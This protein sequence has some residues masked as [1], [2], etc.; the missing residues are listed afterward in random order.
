MSIK[1]TSLDSFCRG[2]SGTAP[3]PGRKEDTAMSDHFE[4]LCQWFES[5]MVPVKTSDLHL[6]MKELANSNEVYSLKHLKRKLEERYKND[7]IISQTEGQANLV[8]FKDAAQFIIKRS[9]LECNNTNE[10]EVM[11]TTAAKLIKAEIQNLKF[12]TEEYPSK[13]DIENHSDSL[14]PLLHQFMQELVSDELKQSSIGQAIMKAIKTRCYIPPLLFGLG[15]ELDH[16]FGSKWL[17]N[18]VYKLGFSISP[19]EITQF[20]KSV[21][22]DKDNSIE[23][24]LKGSFGQWVSDNVDHDVCTLDGKG[25]FHGMGIIVA[26]MTSEM[27]TRK[28]N[29]IRRLKVGR[30]EE[31]VASKA[32]IPILWYEVP[33]RAALSKI[34]FKPIRELQSPH[35]FSMAQGID[36]LW[37]FSFTATREDGMNWNGFMQM[38]HDGKD[39]PGKSEIFML[40][41]IDLSSSDENCIFST[42]VF[43]INQA[44]AMGIVTPSVT[45]DQPLWLKAHEISKS[46][47]LNIV[48][49]LGGFHTLMSFLGSVGAVMK[50]SGLSDLLE[51]VYATNSVKHIISGKAVSRALRGH[52]LVESALMSLLFQKMIDDG[53]DFS[54]LENI[55]QDLLKETTSLAN[56]NDDHNVIAISKAL[57]IIKIELS[58]KS[59]TAKLWI[60]YMEYISIIK[61]FIRAERTGNWHEH[62]EAMRL[63]LNLFAAT[64]HI[65]Y[66][67]S[68]RLYLQSM[69]SLREEHPWLYEQYSKSG[70]H[71][72]RRSDRFWAGLWPDLVIEQCMMRA[73]KSSGG[74][75]RGRG[76]TESTRNLWVGTL[77]ECASIHESMAK[78]TKHR[79][80]SS[81]QHCEAGEARRKRDEKDLLELTDKLT[82]YN[83]FECQDS[84]LQCIF[85]GVTANK[86]DGV[87]CDQAERI[88]FDIQSS[89]DDVIVNKA[90]IKRSKQVKTLAS[91][92]PAVKINGEQVCVDPNILFQRLIMLIDRSEDMTS[93]FEYELTPEPTS[94]F[95]DGLMRKPNKALLGRS[96][97]KESSIIKD[98]VDSALYVIDGGALLHRVCWNLPAT[99]SKIIDQYTS[100]VGRKYGNRTCIIFDGYSAASTKDHEHQR[101]GTRSTEIVFKPTIQVNCKQSDFLSNSKNKSTLIKELSKQLRIDGHEV[102]EC[103]GDADQ[104]I[105]NCLQGNRDGKERKQSNGCC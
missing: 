88:G 62:L 101:R 103:E 63:M 30:M 32:K 91:L 38:H 45:F 96:L 69:Q 31:V 36:L 20:K 56:V 82:Q 18:E 72:I 19:S 11:I 102:V 58:D 57:E 86:D 15:I 89:L 98:K 5:E 81:E 22:A 2:P 67:K 99:G 28:E 46:K 37:E 13:Q 6:K 65:N 34:K 83:P 52:F 94:L 23:V 4:K 27:D 66:A 93:C 70:Y 50:G 59:R 7:I 47:Q 75:T 3:R 85:T 48:I 40:P 8:C 55:Y 24:L 33:D 100:Y 16:K 29:G 105:A 92:L 61:M 43:I 51:M 74:L 21:M 25:T 76:M 49:R 35:P 90:S 9:K 41:I 44:K 77:H 87:N 17:T 84:R 53:V 12:N 73:I 42:L 95:K 1:K 14:A 104:T 39:H 64:G 79:F 68:V 97:V 60:Q 10:G 26:G 80:E 54:S 71:S 78:L